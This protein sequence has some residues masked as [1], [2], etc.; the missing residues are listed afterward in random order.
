MLL[1]PLMWFDRIDPNDPLQLTEG[2]YGL[3]L[4]YTFLN[5]ANIWL[6]GLYGNDDPKGWE[7]VP[8]QRKSAEYGGRLQAPFLSG[9]HWPLPIITGESIRKGAFIRFRQRK[10]ERF[11]KTGLPWTENGMSA[12]A[13]G[14]KRSWDVRTSNSIV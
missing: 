11:P 13:C 1:R 7:A 2:V 14:L 5:N 6:W 8:T 3:L 12:L 4:K 10:N 9:E